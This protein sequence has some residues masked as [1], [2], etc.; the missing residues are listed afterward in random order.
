M[1]NFLNFTDFEVKFG[2]SITKMVGVN[3]AGKTT[4]GL[5]AIWSALRGIAEKN[6]NNQLI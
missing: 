2:D 1:K 3:G 4:V 5:T 6:S